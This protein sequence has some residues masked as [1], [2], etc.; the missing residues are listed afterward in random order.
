LEDPHFLTVSSWEEARAELAFTP[1][2]PSYTAD[3]VLAS[4]SIF[5]RDH[6]HR[7]L[8]IEERSLEAHYGAFSLSQSRPGRE[9]ARRMVV[10]VPYGRWAMEAVVADHE[11]RFY[12]LGPE[13]PPDDLD[14]RSPAV[15]VWH[16]DARFYLVA[17]YTL[18]LSVLARIAHS[19][20]E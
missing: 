4:L 7:D 5:V 18:E 12:D 3:H 16:D 6:T 11:A 10:E 20:Y 15:V 9:E 17:S 2:T 1:L 14:G 8:S 13:V 19:M